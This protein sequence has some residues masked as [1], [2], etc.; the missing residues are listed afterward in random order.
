MLP[1][2]TVDAMHRM[3]VSPKLTPAG[4]E[5][6]F[7]APPLSGDELFYC[8]MLCE[9]GCT[10]GAEKPFD[11]K[12]W[13]FR[14]MRDASGEVRV[15]VAGYCPGMERYS[16]A[17]LEAFLQEDGLGKQLLA[18]AKQHPAHVKPYSAQYRFL[19]VK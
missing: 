7:A 11:C 4:T 10:M 19:Q 2:E 17:Q 12:V 14:M 15:A 8:P 3:G 9:T 1:P 16:D 13:P 5:E 18:Y 6:T